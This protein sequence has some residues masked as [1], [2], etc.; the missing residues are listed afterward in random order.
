MCV[1]CAA[2]LHNVIIVH[3]STLLVAGTFFMNYNATLCKEALGKKILAQVT[4]CTCFCYWRWASSL[5][6]GL[7]IGS[8]TTKRAKPSCKVL[9]AGWDKNCD[10]IFFFAR[11]EG[12]AIGMGSVLLY[13]SIKK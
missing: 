13:Y 1:G 7:L 10:S 2:F 11:W 4:K 3:P 8:I 5:P 6:D 12:V 9:E